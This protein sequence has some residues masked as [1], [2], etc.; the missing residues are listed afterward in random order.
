V[1]ACGDLRRGSRRR[2]GSRGD[3]GMAVSACVRV[4]HAGERLKEG[5]GKLASRAHRTA[6]QTRERATGQGTNKAAPLC[7][8]GE[9][10]RAR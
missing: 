2:F 9:G 10:R 6:T 1:G 8:E 4:V 3:V 5:R 7:R